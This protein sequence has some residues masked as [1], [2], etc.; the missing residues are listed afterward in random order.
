MR[1]KLHVA[2][3]F[4]AI[5]V[6]I[7]LPACSKQTTATEASEVSVM[8]EDPEA[9]QVREQLEE[10]QQE[11]DAQERELRAEKIKFM[12][13][14]IYFKRGSTQLDSAAKMLLDKKAKWLQDNPNISVIIE[15]HCDERGSA[16]YN[17]ALGER[18]A[19][20]AK[21]F[22]IHLGIIESRFRTVSYGEELPMDPG[23]NEEAWAKNRRA[24]FAIE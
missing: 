2:I 11:R 5:P 12:Y 15:G 6:L 3:L 7:Y 24:H 14:D 16:E 23:H 10:E 8:Q 19:E 20:R 9:Q 17:I 18:R 21:A 22:L 4:C 13:E 1:K